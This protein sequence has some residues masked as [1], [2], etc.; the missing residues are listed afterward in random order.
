MRLYN[1]LTRVFKK[2]G[3]QPPISFNHF[4]TFHPFKHQTYHLPLNS[5]YIP[6]TPFDTSK[7][8]DICNKSKIIRDS[9][10]IQEK[11]N[12]KSQE[13]VFGYGEGIHGPKIYIAPHGN[14][15]DF[16]FLNRKNNFPPKDIPIIIDSKFEKKLWDNYYAKREYFTTYRSEPPQQY[17][18]FIPN[19]NIHQ[20]YFYF[21]ST[22]LIFESTLCREYLGT[23]A[24]DEI[25]EGFRKDY[26]K[27][28][29][30]KGITRG[31]CVFSL[32]FDNNFNILK[33]SLCILRVPLITYKNIG[34]SDIITDPHIEKNKPE[35]VNI[36]YKKTYSDDNHN[37]NPHFHE[38][39]ISH[40]E[41]SVNY[42]V[43]DYNF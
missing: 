11:I 42:L 35:Y 31:N 38:S 14:Q 2:E 8:L 12:K 41:F 33:S 13:F 23:M 28:V 24:I 18:A 15:F 34:L 32:T 25:Y 16:E 10:I 22:N 3:P 29:S 30:P 1:K 27:I 7:I 4:Y 9:S 40:Y 6:Q 39:S 5:A 19:A 37:K 43:K 36:A 21:N 26:Y 17:I 20:I